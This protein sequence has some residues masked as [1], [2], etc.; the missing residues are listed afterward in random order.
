[1]M[2]VRLELLGQVVDLLDLAL[3]DEGPRADARPDLEDL[4]DHAGAGRLGQAFQFGHGFLGIR[5]FL[6]R[7]GQVDEDGIFHEFRGSPR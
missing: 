1:M 2:S 6:G 7:D 3:A 4:L 5:F